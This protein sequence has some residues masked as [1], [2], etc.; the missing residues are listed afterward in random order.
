MI[1]I[2]SPKNQKNILN[3]KF[4]IYKVKVWG[5]GRNPTHSEI[6]CYS[7]L[8]INKYKYPNGI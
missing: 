7:I 6:F 8:T 4:E 5:G 2:E 1:L 3:K